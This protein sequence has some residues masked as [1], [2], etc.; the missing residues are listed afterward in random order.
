MGRPE[1][2]TRG[3][4]VAFAVGAA[5]LAAAAAV[6]AATIRKDDVEAID[7]GHLAPAVD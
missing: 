1:A 2:L 3:Y 4:H 5:M 6:I 7:A